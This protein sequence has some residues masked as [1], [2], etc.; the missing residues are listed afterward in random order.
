MGAKESSHRRSHAD[1][2]SRKK[3]IANKKE[4]EEPDIWK[5]VAGYGKD[6]DAAIESLNGYLQYH[7]G[8]NLEEEN[9]TQ[10]LY[11]EIKKQKFYVY[12]SPRNNVVICYIDVP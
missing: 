1:G 9:G 4:K 5:R 2:E 12:S 7:Y 8:I 11:I 3:L 6:E 10:S